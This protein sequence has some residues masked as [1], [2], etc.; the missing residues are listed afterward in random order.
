LEQPVLPNIKKHLGPQLERVKD[1]EEF[2]SKYVSDKHVI[3]GPY[4]ENGRW[5]VEVPR[6]YTNAAV[7][8]RMKLADGGKNA[9][10]A[11]LVAKVAQAEFS[12]LVDE[13]VLKIYTENSDFAVFLTEFLLG[14]PFWLK[15]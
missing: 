8:L 9:G 6:K 15:T 3:A 2:L 11:E 14:K 12:I 13:E 7:L 5:I 4:V 1:C 10:V